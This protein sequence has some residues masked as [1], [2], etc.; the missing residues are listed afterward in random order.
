MTLSGRPAITL[1]AF[2]SPVLAM[3]N[4]IPHALLL[5]VAMAP[6]WVG[7][8]NAGLL[9]ILPAFLVERGIGMS[10][11]V[12]LLAARDRAAEVPL[13]L[14]TVAVSI[15]V[16][17]VMLLSTVMV[18]MMVINCPFSS[19]VVVFIV[20]N[21]LVTSPTVPLAL[22][23]T[24]HVRIRCHMHKVPCHQLKSV[25]VFIWTGEDLHLT[26]AKI[27][28]PLESGIFVYHF[29]TMYSPPLMGCAAFIT[30]E[31]RWTRYCHAG[32]GAINDC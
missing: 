25:N 17:L 15:L 27:P 24:V 4:V 3:P 8:D 31:W 21:Y 11:V 6:L 2:V 12:P 13:L 7:V 20:V 19:F 5:P 16:M 23:I 1:F 26:P 28:E 30:W 32:H 14:V 29:V 22:S 9:G 18:V 10:V